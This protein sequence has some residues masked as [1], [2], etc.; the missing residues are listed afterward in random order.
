MNGWEQGTRNW[1]KLHNQEPYDI[2]PSL[3]VIMF[4]GIHPVV[5]FTDNK[6]TL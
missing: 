1:S 4:N 6:L 2:Y 3:N 5:E